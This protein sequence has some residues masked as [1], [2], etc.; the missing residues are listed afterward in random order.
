M[1]KKEDMRNHC[2]FRGKSDVKFL[3]DFA[4]RIGIQVKT[5]Q[6]EKIEDTHLVSLIEKGLETK[7]VSRDDVMKVLGK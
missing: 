4:R 1:Y 5:I 2:C 7:N 3:T 6:T